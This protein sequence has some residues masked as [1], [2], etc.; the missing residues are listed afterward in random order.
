RSRLIPKCAAMSCACWSAARTASSGCGAA[1]RRPSSIAARLIGAAWPPNRPDARK[2][3]C[4]VLTFGRAIVAPI[5]AFLMH[6]GGGELQL[7]LGGITFDDLELR[8][9]DV[10]L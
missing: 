2:P 4:L 8:I 7:A 1:Q 10:A 9:P 3:K 5:D 6:N